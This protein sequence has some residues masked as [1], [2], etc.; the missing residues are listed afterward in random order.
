M[1]SH[2]VVVHFRQWCPTF[3]TRWRE[4]VGVAGIALARAASSKVYILLIFFPI[5]H[6]CSIEGIM[7]TLLFKCEVWAF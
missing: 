5:F 3:R 7:I 4:M 2:R 1:Q 6:G